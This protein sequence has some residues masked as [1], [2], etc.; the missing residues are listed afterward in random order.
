MKGSIEIMFFT[1][2]YKNLIKENNKILKNIENKFPI[3][4]PPKK[5]EEEYRFIEINKLYFKVKNHWFFN[6][7]EAQGWEPQTYFTYK[8][9]LTK[10]T[11]YVDI[12]TWVGLTIMFAS[13]I[14]VNK[15]Y[16]IEANKL[17]YEITCENCKMN[18]LTEKA[19][20]D[21]LCIIDKDNTLVNFG[22][23]NSSE[24]SSAS[25]IKGNQWLINSKKLTTYLKE[26]NIQDDKLFIKIDIEGAEELIVEDLKN[27]AEKKDII[28]YLSIHPTFWDNK[29]VAG[30]NILDAC[31]K[32]QEVKDSANNNLAKEK[33]E[34]MIFTEDSHPAWGTIHGNFFEV[35]LINT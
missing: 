19:N 26:N 31:Y 27:L 2:K 6:E 10:D 5:K 25:S 17:S 8:N 11:T 35:I 7:F 3:A 12:G 9:Y 14:G 1:K 29:E 22:S 34:E 30:R 20:I 33:L 18:K 21:N 15:I 16:G 24:T 13:E 28:I 4:N 32:F 23:T